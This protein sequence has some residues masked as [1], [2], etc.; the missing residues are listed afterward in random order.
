MSLYPFWSLDFELRADVPDNVVRVLHAVAENTSPATKDLAALPQFARRYLV[1]WHGMLSDE[2][3]QVAGTP[4]RLYRARYASGLCLS[5]AFSQHD[6]EFADLGWLFWLW[7]LNLVRRP[8]GSDV[9]VVGWHGVY[10]FDAASSLVSVDVHGV[11]EGGSHIPW[12]YLE[13][14]LADEEKPS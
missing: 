5:I 8:V 4:V 14:T 12:G 13:A 6:D 7:V 3:E 11:H 1:D 10:R 2:D 9:Q